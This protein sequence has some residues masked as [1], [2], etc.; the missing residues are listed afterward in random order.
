M[1]RDHGLEYLRAVACLFIILLHT[2]YSTTLMYSIRLNTFWRFGGFQ[3]V[4]DCLMWAVP[5][6]VM[7]TGA[8]LLPPGKKI[9]YDRLFKRYITRVLKAILVF[10]VLF[11]V[12]E[13]IFNPE[14]R[15]VQ[16][17]LANLYEVF[18]GDTWSHMWYLYCLL[19]LYLLL[20]AYKKIAEL[21]SERDILYLLGVYGFFEA[22]LP[23]LGIGNIRCGFYIHVSSIYPFWL[24]LGY[25]LHRWGKRYSRRMYGLLALGATAVIAGASLLRT[26]YGVHALD[27][28]F[29]YSS[30]LTILQAAGIA[31]WFF[32]SK[33]D[34]ASLAG[35]ALISIDRHSFGV[36]L[37]HMAYIRLLYKHLHFDPFAMPPALGV[38]IVVAFA[39]VL[40]Y[41][42]DMVMKKLPLFKSIV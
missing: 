38:L 4:T 2:V 16:A 17:V 1:E 6:F 35:K 3:A 11:G 30:P 5:C 27:T 41:V 7:V 28:L 15:T 34:S 9:G 42:T 23:L 13:Y 26:W 12:L 32:Q 33:T 40:A 22:L 24:F 18:T 14:Q 31:G 36:Y 39:F 10:G 29:T 37:I 19:G 20:P 21:S 8:L 25:W